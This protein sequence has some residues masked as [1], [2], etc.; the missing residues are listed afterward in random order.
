MESKA[1]FFFVAHMDLYL[2]PF[3]DPVVLNGVYMGLASW[4]V[5]SPNHQNK[6][7]SEVPGIQYAQDKWIYFISFVMR[8]VYL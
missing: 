6:G 3:D 8:M 1:R 2:E 5:L 4:R 7:P